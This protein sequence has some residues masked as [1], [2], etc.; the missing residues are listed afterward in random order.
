MANVNLYE[1]QNYETNNL[2]KRINEL[3]NDF[4]VLKNI[5]EKTKVVIKV[6][7]I[8]AMEPEKGA[9]THP[10]LLK[11]LVLYLLSKKCFV[12][13]GDSPGG[14]YTK[15]YLNHVYKVTRMTET[16]AK[17]NDNFNT[18]TTTYDKSLVLKSF[19]Y[20]SYLDD[21]DVL[22]NFCKLK[23]HG[24]MK[25]SCAVKNLFGTIPGTV[26]PQYHYRFPKY[27]DFANMLIDINE[28]FKADLNIVDAIVGMEGNGPTMGTPR[29]VGL[30]LASQN[31][32]EL[33]YICAKLI[34]EDD[35]ETVKQSIIRGLCKP[36]EIKLNK[37]I[38]KYIIKDYALIAEKKSLVFFKNK[39]MANIGSKLFENKPV[40]TKKCV[41]CGKCASV[42]PAKAIEII[43]C[44]ASIDR[45]KCI[46]C[47]CCQEFC[48]FGAINVK[49]S[50]FINLLH[51]K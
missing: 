25:M 35:V 5:K 12:V 47:Y 22:I 23:T 1:C 46:K 44:K 19:E 6:N 14:V 51:K 21:A 18:K 28:Y 39:I 13:I 29:K 37:N 40:V 26:K 41:G 9:T 17:L 31:P 4:D 42:C 20:T 7:L 49:K 24:M 33:D 43:D 50:L 34:G 30:I 15:Q 2:E 32:Y 11:A 27:V 48:P 16:G 10:A 3:V 45:T 8:S 36:E 38:D